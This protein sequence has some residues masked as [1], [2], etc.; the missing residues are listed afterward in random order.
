ME[1]ME[2]LVPGRYVYI[3]FVRVF[4]RNYL[5]YDVCISFHFCIKAFCKATH[6]TYKTLLVFTAYIRE[7]YRVYK[8]I[9]YMT[10]LP[11]AAAAPPPPFTLTC[12]L[13]RWFNFRLATNHAKLAVYLTY[14]YFK[15][16]HIHSLYLERF[17]FKLMQHH[18]FFSVY[19][20]SFAWMQ[21]ETKWKCLD[22]SLCSL[23]CICVYAIL[24]REWRYCS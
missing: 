17:D 18:A 11:P 4:Y 8:N 20:V 23:L 15:H 16:T 14:E 5:Y 6:Y 19:A 2:K 12:E 1:Y 21:Y 10:S 24:N 7:F 22:V 3:C 13:A 9:T